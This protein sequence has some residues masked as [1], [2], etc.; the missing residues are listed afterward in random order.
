MI[1]QLAA[2]VTSADEEGRK[3]T[4]PKTPKHASAPPRR[5]AGWRTATWMPR[6]KAPLANPNRM[7]CGGSPAATNTATNA[8]AT[9]AS[10][11]RG[12]PKNRPRESSPRYAAAL[13]RI[14]SAMATVCRELNTTGAPKPI[15]IPARI[16]IVP[17]KMTRLTT[18]VDIRNPPRCSAARSRRYTHAN[19]CAICRGSPNRSSSR[20][21]ISSSPRP[22]CRPALTKSST[23]A[24]NSRSTSR[25]RFSDGIRDAAMIS[26]INRS[27]LGISLAPQHGVHGA[28][29]VLPLPFVLLRGLSPLGGQRIIFTLAAIVAGAP[30]RTH[31]SLFF[32]LVQRRVERA[33]LEFERVRAA[34]RS[35]LENLVA[36]H[37]AARKQVQQQQ[38]DAPLEQ[39]TVNFHSSASCFVI[40]GIKRAEG[41]S[42]R[43]WDL[44]SRYG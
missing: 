22:L 37:L 31:E 25:R 3:N 32:E 2:V 9:T 10:A 35:R 8:A 1:S 40:Q 29:Q 14:S 28:S 5:N 41:L 7:Y 21:S 15:I 11:A 38:T 18:T 34:H 26:S 6:S 4:A 19:C 30:L 12:R 16:E 24:R 17:A 42:T 44:L 23:C 13:A 20:R 39:L 36:V 27:M 43:G 33:F